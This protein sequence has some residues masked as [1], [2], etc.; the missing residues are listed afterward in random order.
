MSNYDVDIYEKEYDV[1]HVEICRNN[2]LHERFDGSVFRY[3]DG[4]AEG[5][6]TRLLTQGSMSET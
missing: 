2:Y 6:E 3:S 4:D 5:L 1:K